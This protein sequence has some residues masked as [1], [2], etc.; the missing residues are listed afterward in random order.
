MNVLTKEETFA[1]ERATAWRKQLWAIDNIDLHNSDGSISLKQHGL[2][3]NIR[4]DT[5]VL[6][7][8]IERLHK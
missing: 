6:L 3:S 7:K 4:N 2:L 5:R 8:A 1:V